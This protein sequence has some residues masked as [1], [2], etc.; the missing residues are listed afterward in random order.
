LTQPSAA[1]SLAARQA[2]AII[3]SGAQVVVSADHACLRQLSGALKALG[4][5]LPV[6][7]PIELL[8]SSIRAAGQPM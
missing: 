6:H 2:A 7:H 5:P 3:E 4:H 1:S 8:W